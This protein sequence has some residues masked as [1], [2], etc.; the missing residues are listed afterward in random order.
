VITLRLDPVDTW[1]F[2]QGIPTQAE[3]ASQLAR[4][5]ALPPSPWTVA[6]ALRVALACAKGWDGAGIWS[7]EVARV[8]GDGP[9]DLGQISLAGPL[10]VEGDTPLV[11]VPAHI[12]E[13]HGALIP[14]IGPGASVACDLGPS[15]RL[16]ECRSDLTSLVETRVGTLL[17]LSQACR[18]MRGQSV[19]KSATQHLEE[20]WALEPRTGIARE[21]A[22]RTAAEG[23]L[24][25]IVHVRPR[26]L[27]VGLTV[28]A[29]DMGDLWTQA[30]GLVRI[31]AEGRL[32]ELSVAQGPT[33]DVAEALRPDKEV[34]D[35]IANTGRAAL[36]VLTPALLTAEQW[37]GA[38]PL[39]ELGGAR[40][41]C[42]CGPR[43]IRLGGWDGRRSSP[44]P[45]RSFVA[46]GSV[47]FLDHNPPALLASIEGLGEVPQIGSHTSA[48]FGLVLVGAWPEG[49]S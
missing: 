39:E 7:S 32:A 33:A 14:V 8:V 10:L 5:S 17:P 1:H 36:A 48:G 24:F 38:A 18:L 47:L 12:L 4:T 43:P 15:V 41:V 29:R 46:A 9:Y 30:E 40:I 49:F 44:T 22:T 6:G 2:G 19:P 42:A 31:G 21:R 20:L 23:A 35:A 45:Q 27:G 28:L 3:S 37:R 25:D 13:A 16:P 34:L 11:P 26:R